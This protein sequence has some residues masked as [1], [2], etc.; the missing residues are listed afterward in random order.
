MNKR[1][2]Y[3]YEKQVAVLLAL[4]R[5]GQLLCTGRLHMIVC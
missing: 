3:I 5:S 2:W 1:R 4:L